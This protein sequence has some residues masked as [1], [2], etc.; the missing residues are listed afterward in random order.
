MTGD[1]MADAPAVTVKQM[2]LDHEERI[3]PLEDFQKR[4]EP[5]LFDAADG[6]VPRLQDVE[7]RQER[8]DAMFSL[9]RWTLGFAGLGVFL[10]LVDMVGQAM[11]ILH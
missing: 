1:P 9:V 11:G 4:A 10:A 2:V 3:G 8:I 5:V 7:E 6:L